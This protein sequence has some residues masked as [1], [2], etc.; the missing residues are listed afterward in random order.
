MRQM[1]KKG[2]VTHK[3]GAPKLD[4]PERY[5]SLAI[6]VSGAQECRKVDM[7]WLYGLTCEEPV[8]KYGKLIPRINN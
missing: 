7:A 1:K 8:H 2:Q 5:S 6:E 3:A 4:A